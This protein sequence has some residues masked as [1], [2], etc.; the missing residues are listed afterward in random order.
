MPFVT[1]RRDSI[2]YDGT[3]GA[4][5]AGVWCSGIAFVSDTGSVLTYTDRSGRER[6]AEL[7]SWFIISG[8]DDG[9]PTVLSQED[10][11]T[12]FVEIPVIPS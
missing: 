7:G 12:Y 5:I 10:Y 2:R 11:T 6:T 1:S 4:H 8:V 9:D 3:N